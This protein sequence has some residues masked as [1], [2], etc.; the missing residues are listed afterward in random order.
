MT[1]SNSCSSVKLLTYADDADI[2]ERTKRDVTASFSA[3]EQE[4]TKM[5]VAVNESKTKFMLLTSRD[6]RRIDFQITADDY[7]F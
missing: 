4:F 7:T 2:I 3:I 6:M 5:G 1:L